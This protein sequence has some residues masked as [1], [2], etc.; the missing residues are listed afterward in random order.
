MQRYPTDRYPGHAVWLDWPWK[1]H[2]L[3]NQEDK[4]I[5]FEMHNLTVDPGKN[6]NLITDRPERAGAMLSNLESWLTSV[7]YSLNGDDYNESLAWNM[8][9]SI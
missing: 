5:R 7:V 3:K 4:N 2:R 6:N 9:P 8:C 1:L